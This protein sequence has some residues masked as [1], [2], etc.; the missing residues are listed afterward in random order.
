VLAGIALLNLFDKHKLK[1]ASVQE[2]LDIAIWEKL[3][4]KWRDAFPD[5]N[6]DKIT[7]RQLLQHKSGFRI[8]D[9]EANDNAKGTKMSYVLVCQCHLSP[10]AN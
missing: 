3:P 2:Q 5:R 9:T 8:G 1:D 4:A 6:L 7:Y 10:R